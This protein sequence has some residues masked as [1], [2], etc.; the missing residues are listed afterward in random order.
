MSIED[1]QSQNAD[2]CKT[3]MQEQGTLLCKP[4]KAVMFVSGGAEVSPAGLVSSHVIE[5]SHHRLSSLDRPHFHESKELPV[6]SKRAPTTTS[7]E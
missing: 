4:L 1:L 6:R 7:F 2:L 3:E 5:P